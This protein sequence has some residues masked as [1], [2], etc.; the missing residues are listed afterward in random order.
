MLQGKVDNIHIAG[1]AS[2]VPRKKIDNLKLQFPD[3]DKT[4]SSIGV[5]QRRVTQDTICTSD[6]CFAAAEKLLSQLDWDR[7]S[8]DCL[9]FISQTPDYFLPATAYILQDRLKLKNA[10]VVFDINLGCSG[11]V[12]G[13]WVVSQLLQNFSAKRALLLVGDTISKLT[14]N[15][16]R[17]TLPLFG[18]AGSATALEKKEKQFSN[19]SFCIGADGEGWK[20]LIVKKGAFR[21]PILSD[22]QPFL[23]MDGNE[24]FTFTLKRVPELIHQVIK[25]AQWENDQ[26]DYFIFHQANAFMLDFLRKKLKLTKE[27]FLL[28]LATFGN[29]SSASIPLTMVSNPID[30][31]NNKVILA[32][33]GVGY[34]W[35][36]A[37][38]NCQENILL[39]PIIE[40]DEL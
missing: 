14:P 10:S 7:D 23:F 9:I 4:I 32:G 12:Y 28:S 16:D 1:V 11:Y 3:I 25:T 5:H 13:L 29:T 17:A 21:N 8:V 34:S 35:A 18:D 36:A 38:L 20:N 22:E 2:A 37:A 19:I 27:Q 33:F 24:I 15:N 26:I 30:Y 39:L 40:M 6:L 31:A